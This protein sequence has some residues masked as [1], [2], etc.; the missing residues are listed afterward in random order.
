MI[1]LMILLKRRPGMSDEEFYRYWREDHGRT[2]MG[3]KEFSR[4]IRRY[5]QSPKKLGANSAFASAESDYDGVA[6]LWFDDVDSM[7]RAFAEP[8][9]LEIV[10]P[11]EHKFVDLDACRVLVVDEL[12]KFTPQGSAAGA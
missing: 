3:T 12:P 6:E 4:H 1:K 11:D 2:V 9:Y 7:N 10:R 5:V 8:K